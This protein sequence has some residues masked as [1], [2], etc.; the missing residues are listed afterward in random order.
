MMCILNSLAQSSHEYEADPDDVTM[1]N[2]HI[3]VKLTLGF[4]E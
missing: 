3:N 2:S 1:Q 4:D